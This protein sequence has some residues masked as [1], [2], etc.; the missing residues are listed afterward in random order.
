[1]NATIFLDYIG[2]SN[3]YNL[4]DEGII[5][6]DNRLGVYRTG[7]NT[8]KKH[9]HGGGIRLVSSDSYKDLFDDYESL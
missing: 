4:L 6:Y 7:K 2:D 8:G 9:N 3:F 5:R 1:M